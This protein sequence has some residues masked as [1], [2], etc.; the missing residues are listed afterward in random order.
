MFADCILK[1]AGLLI[2]MKTPAAPSAVPTATCTNIR[3]LASMVHC[4]AGVPDAGTLPIF[5]AHVCDDVMKFAPA[6]V[7]V[8]P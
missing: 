3:L 6:T 7:S 1:L 8:R 4:A 2:D 5:A